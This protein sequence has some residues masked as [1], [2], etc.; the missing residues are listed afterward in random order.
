MTYV[1]IGEA[2]PEAVDDIVAVD[3]RGKRYRYVSMILQNG[4]K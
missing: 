3:T 1:K 2:F 4:T